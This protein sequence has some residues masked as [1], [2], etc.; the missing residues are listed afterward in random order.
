VTSPL[1]AADVLEKLTDQQRK[2]AVRFIPFAERVAKGRTLRSNERADVRADAMFGLVKAAGRGHPGRPFGP[3]ARACIEGQI[4]QGKRDRSGIRSDRKAERPRSVSLDALPVDT[5][6]DLQLM[7]GG[8]PISPNQAAEDAEL[9]RS[10][11]MLAP[12]EV[13]A[14]RLYYQ[15]DQSQ[16]KIAAIMGISQMEVSRILVRARAR[17]KARAE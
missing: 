7:S 10:V 6:P 17:L 4:L 11:D 1:R 8:A 3:Y 14:I 16:R 9:W 12:R 2:L 5:E 15:M 13:R